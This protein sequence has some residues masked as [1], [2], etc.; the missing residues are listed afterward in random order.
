LKTRRVAAV[1][2]ATLTGIVVA[3]QLTLAVGAPWGAYAMA[4]AYPG[5]FPPGLRVTAV[6]QALV[7]IA[8]AAVVLS[9][10]AV[11]FT[12]LARASRWLVWVV[13]VLCALSVLLNLITPSGGERMVWAPVAL[14]LLTTS[15][16]VA[17]G[18]QITKPAA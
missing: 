3:F 7:L 6:I 10:A 11:S 4:G 18:P 12:A 9:R 5:Q 16:R 13:V 1:V 8:F 17:T 15:L 2:Y 14:T